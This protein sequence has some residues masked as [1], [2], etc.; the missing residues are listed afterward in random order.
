[1]TV[2]HALESKRQFFFARVF[3]FAVLGRALQH[4]GVHFQQKQLVMNPEN[5]EVGF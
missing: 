1:M 4:M 2:P 3:F 5:P